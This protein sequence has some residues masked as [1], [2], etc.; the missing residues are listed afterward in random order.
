MAAH[1]GVFISYRRS[2]SG[3]YAGRLWEELRDRYGE[4]AVFWDIDTI[5]PG[6]ELTERIK[7]GLK[8]CGVLLA[9]IGPSWLDTHDAA[10]RRR[11]DD[12]ADYVRNEIAW[13]L[14]PES[15]IRVVPV[16]IEGT[17]MPAPA[18]LPSELRDLPD[19]AGVEVRNRSWDYDVALL[20]QAIDPVLFPPS[21]TPTGLLGPLRRARSAMQADSVRLRRLLMWSAG[22]VASALALV[23]YS[24]DALDALELR[25]VDKR[26]V[27]RGT[28]KAP[29]DVVIVGVDDRTLARYRPP[30]LM[31]RALHARL[32]DRLSAA[33]AKTIGYDFT[34]ERRRGTRRRGGPDDDLIQAV[35]RAALDRHVPT[36][37]AAGPPARFDATAQLGLL[38][39]D[40]SGEALRESLGAQLGVARLAQD[41]T[42][43]V[44]RRLVY[45][46]Y[47]ERSFSVM[48]ADVARG[49]TI[50]PAMAT[51]S[52]SWIAFAGPAHTYPEISFR[53][54][55][56]GR[57]SPDRLRGKIVLV[58]PYSDQLGDVHATP[59]GPAYG[60]E[61]EA[62]AIDTLRSRASLRTVGAIVT[63]LSIL[64]LAFSAP[65]GALRWGTSRAAL[66][67]AAL[68]LAYLIVAQV[69][70]NSGVVLVVVYPLLAGVLGVMGAAVARPLA[71]AAQRRASRPGARPTSAVAGQ[72]P[73]R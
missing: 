66:L 64:A 10:G 30:P 7:L 57:V 9:L 12:P 19:R 41:P 33:G 11:L 45:S 69:A 70:F 36:V 34:F 73:R 72:P 25:T 54:V 40:N 63:A 35:A 53:D 50:D 31:S 58:G 2:D 21:P 37:I 42:D 32:I 8:D 38:F 5:D 52:R 22:I 59:F 26:F 48:V 24:A 27:I 6:V 39:L 60:V 14:D 47:G 18:D 68:A 62:N 43:L 67:T 71:D 61:V 49:G 44:M 13:A 46:R 16:L 23:A 65:L 20:T 17:P 28:K 55:L 29:A 56:E 51:G 1:R 15:G 4:A 3:G